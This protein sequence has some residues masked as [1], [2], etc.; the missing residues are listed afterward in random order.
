MAGQEI[1]IP[2]FDFSGFYYAEIIEALLVYKRE[3]VPEISNE[4]PFETG[5]QLLRAFALIGHLNNVLL[6]LT[7]QEV[8]L[9]SAQVR[10]NVV[11]ILALLGFVPRAN[12][13]STTT[14]RT[15]LTQSY[16]ATTLLVPDNAL[17]GTRRRASTPSILF[18]SD[19]SITVSPTDEI[20][21]CWL[22]D[23]VAAWSDFTL[24]ANTNGGFPNAGAVA[25]RAMYFAHDSVFTDTIEFTDAGGFDPGDDRT[26]TP[27]AVHLQYFDGEVEDASPDIVTV[28][29]S[30]I[31][32]DV[33]TLLGIESKFG[34]FVTVTVNATGAAERLAI[35]VDGVGN[36]VETTG[37]LGQTVVSTTVTDYTVGTMW[38]DVQIATDNTAAVASETESYATGDTIL[39]IFP[40]TLTRFPVEEDSLVTWTYLA[41]GLPKTATYDL[42]TGAIGGDANAGTTVNRITGVSNL[43]TQSVP[44]AVAIIVVYDRKAASLRASGT[45]TWLPPFNTVDDWVKGQLPEEL[46]STTGPTLDGY[47]FRILF[48]A[49]GAGTLGNFEFDRVFWDSGGM[50]IRVPVTQGQTVSESLGSGDGTASQVFTPGDT[51]VIEGSILLTVDGELWTQVEDFFASSEVDENFTVTIDSD[52]LATILTGDGQNG[53]VVPVGTNNVSVEYRIGANEDG[54]VGA[55]QIE[56]SRSGLSRVKN[57]TNPRAA[58]GWI[59]QEGSDALSLEKLKRDGVSSL[60]TLRRAVSPSDVEFLTSRWKLG[61]QFPFKRSRAIEN[62]F[63]LKTVKLIVV[64]VGGGTSSP[65]TRQALDEHFNGTINEGGT[66]PGVLVAN[67]R[68]TSV[69]YTPSVFDLTLTVEGGNEAAI[70][71]ALL[72]ELQP[73]AQRTDTSFR[74]E[75]GQ[76]VSVAAISA[77]VF[78]ADRDVIN[79][80]ITS[81][82]ADTN[83]ADDELPQIDPLTLN[84][85]VT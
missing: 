32:F 22:L 38:H 78:A 42:E 66:E 28:Q 26:A 23:E 49:F 19:A 83:L 5:V 12:V 60:R 35:Q 4:N 40:G 46:R 58:S 27:V 72:G 16:T 54:N 82:A 24:L 52:G 9:P 79:V 39:Q 62:G 10:E 50:Y 56:V 53:K 69:D 33:N 55:G 67:Q 64:P 71:A 59:A 73:E 31:R 1:V 44:D 25:G 68:V 34:D 20:D 15:Q 84:L 36:F 37:F 85:T 41:G 48:S 17:F 3:N 81:P 70:R 45:I 63:G 43:V 77:I 30:N 29:A 8:Y 80:T 47:W 65:A 14:L 18:E 21:A 2:D 51:P 13:P 11:R 6:D 74:W 57:T 75:F 76:V 7:A 61:N